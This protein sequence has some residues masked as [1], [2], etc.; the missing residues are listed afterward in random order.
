M[1]CDVTLSTQQCLDFGHMPVGPC[2]ARA[3]VPASACSASPETLGST[4]HES[5]GIAENQGITSSSRCHRH[6]WSQCRYP[7][8]GVLA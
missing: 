6:G 3:S 2:R 4:V 5:R 7:F 1:R 8:P